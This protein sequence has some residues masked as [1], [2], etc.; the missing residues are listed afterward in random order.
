MGH[1]IW[2]LKLLF[3]YRQLDWGVGR[4]K[5]WERYLMQLPQMVIFPLGTQ[6]FTF[7]LALFKVWRM[8]NASVQGKKTE[9][10]NHEN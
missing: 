6:T 5:F 8:K 1:D 9:N 10:L 3:L 2:L 7:D 4:K